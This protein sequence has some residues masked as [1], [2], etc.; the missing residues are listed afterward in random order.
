[1][2]SPNCT[3][4][5]LTATCHDRIAVVTGA[6][7]NANLIVYTKQRPGYS[8]SSTAVQY[9]QQRA[10][11]NSCLHSC[12][13]SCISTLLVATG[14]VDSLLPAWDCAS[15][16]CVQHVQTQWSSTALVLLSLNCA[17]VPS[18]SCE[19]RPSALMMRLDLVQ[20]YDDEEHAASRQALKALLPR[21][22]QLR[23]SE[24]LTK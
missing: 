9:G 18:R 12:G 10:T 23:L 6:S 15:L 2:R 22:L 24:L 20:Y 17:P 16:A 11:D 7:N 5:A 1:M 8:A 21:Q 3:D 14:S 19:A 4:F 13:F